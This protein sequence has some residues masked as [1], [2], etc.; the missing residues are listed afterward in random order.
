MLV[1]TVALVSAGDHASK[2]NTV[3]AM[4]PPPEAIL[5]TDDGA[6]QVLD[7]EPI[8]KPDGPLTLTAAA[9]TNACSQAPTLLINDGGSTDNIRDFNFIVDGS[10]PVLSCMWGDPPDDRGYRTAWYKFQPAD[11]GLVA[12]STWSSN[13]DTVIA[14]HKGACE[15]LV[16]VACNDDDNYWSSRV[17]LEVQAGETYYVEVADWHSAA[18]GEM[19][20][21]LQSEQQPIKSHWK[22]AAAGSSN[23]SFRSRHAVVADGSKLY[24][25]AGQESIGADAVRTPSM[26]VYDTAT[27]STQYLS[28]MKGGDDQ[29]GYSN[30]TA[31]LVNGRIYMPA[32]YTGGLNDG[33]H[34]VYIIGEDRWD[35][36]LAS[37]NSWPSGEPFIFSQATPYSFSAPPGN[38]YFLSGGMTGAFPVSDSSSGWSPKG[39]LYF[40]SV[41]SN[42]WLPLIPM[43]VA[44]FGHIAAKQSINGQDHLCVAGGMGGIPEFNRETLNSTYCFN[45]NLGTWSEFAPLNHERY[46]ATSA[47]DAQGNWYVFGGYDNSDNLVGITERYDS[48]ADEWVVLNPAYSVV[49]PRAWPRGAYVGNTVWLIGGEIVD[50]HVTYIVQRTVLFQGSNFNYLPLITGQD[51][52]SRQNDTPAT[53]RQLAFPTSIYDR[54][55][56]PFDIVN[57][58]SFD[59]PSPRQPVRIRLDGLGSGN[60][61]DLVL[62]TD[63]KAIETSSRQP[64]TKREDFTL[65]LDPGRYYIAVERVFPLV[66]DDPRPGPYLLQILSG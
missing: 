7:L 54:L 56:T 23:D 17:E 11:Y 35:K 6:I 13:Y 48:K 51:G 65:T 5:R 55:Y 19:I 15:A 14:V 32:G 64:G 21:N 59:V 1:A 18:S 57:F 28:N 61:L 50:E 26:Y 62:Y 22:A 31:A 58:Y 49:P 37:D 25:I 8:A 16:E 39:E 24:V 42:S 34:W 46:F 66:G 29:Q 38:G 9:A 20:L 40:Y 10:D 3:A 43:P 63:N 33:T 4:P 36:N 12:L 53:A 60:H 30:T 2:T 47:V 44:R 41:D 27:G 45:I 52:D